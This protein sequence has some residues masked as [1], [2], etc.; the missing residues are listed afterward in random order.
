M[1][2]DDQTIWTEATQGR[3]LVHSVDDAEF[4][5]QRVVAAAGRTVEWVLGHDGQPLDL[6]RRMKFDTVG[7]HPVEGRALNLVEQVNQTWTYVAA[8][9]A[10]RHLLVAHPDAGGFR[11]A[12]GADMSQ[13]LDVMSVADGL[14][15]AETCAVVHP[16]NNRKIKK[17]VA[18]LAGRP[19]LHRY[20]FFMC[21]LFPGTVRR[22]QFESGGVQVWSVDV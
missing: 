22:H 15:G 12:P 7:W 18:K 5:M 3:L 4:L 20:A 16:M 9:A 14:V 11:I 6:L 17:D 10:V 1:R 21:P 8:I 2:P 19:E 13:P